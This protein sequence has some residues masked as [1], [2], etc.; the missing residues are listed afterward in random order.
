MKLYAYN[1]ETMELLAIAEGETNQECEKKMEA[2]GFS[3][4]SIGWTYSPAFGFTGG[5]IDTG[6]WAEV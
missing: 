3:D 4:D 5:V 2:S 6:D 1:I